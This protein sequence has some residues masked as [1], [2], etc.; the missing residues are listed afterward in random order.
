MDMKFVMERLS[1]STLKAVFIEQ[2]N[3]LDI[4][5]YFQ[6]SCTSRICIVDFM[7]N[8]PA[9]VSAEAKKYYV[10]RK[11][12]CSGFPEFVFAI[13]SNRSEINR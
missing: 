11:H 12:Q 8:V 7:S 5:Q 10:D 3:V 1:Y 9:M 13:K 6:Q 4:A 2:K